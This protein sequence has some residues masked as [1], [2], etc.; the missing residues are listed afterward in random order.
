LN[1]FIAHLLHRK[2]KQ[3]KIQSAKNQK[4]KPAKALR[5]YC[6]NVKKCI[7]FAVFSLQNLK[8]ALFVGE[9]AA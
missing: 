2:Q 6:A 5:H 3:L 9:L 4:P 7:F 8:S 1:R